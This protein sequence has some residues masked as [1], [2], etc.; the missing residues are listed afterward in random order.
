MA[1]SERTRRLL[2]GGEGTEVEY[3]TKI[4]QE[5]NDI[6]VAFDLFCFRNTLQRAIVLK[7]SLFSPLKPWRL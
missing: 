5:F 1:L 4:T 2:A 6:L 3:K 7:G